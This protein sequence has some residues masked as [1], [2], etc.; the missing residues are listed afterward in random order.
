MKTK[1]V[2]KLPLVICLALGLLT[3]WVAY[4]PFAEGS[5]SII[6]GWGWTGEGACCWGNV[7]D[8]CLNYPWPAICI[9]DRMVNICNG[10]GA[11]GGCVFEWTTP[12]IGN[13]YCSNA[14]DTHCSA[15]W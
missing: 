4:S 15:G 13:S 7:N 9:N 2:S 3:A 12:C 1:I 10:S 6:G 8:N 5:S 11:G 14:I